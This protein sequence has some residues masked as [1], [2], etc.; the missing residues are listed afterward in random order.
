L[1]RQYQLVTS[2]ASWRFDCGDLIEVEIHDGLEGVTGCAI[3]SSVGKRVKPLGI[4]ALLGDQFGDSVAPALRSATAIDGSPVADNYR[5][6]MAGAVAGLALGAGEG[7]LARGP[8]SGL[9]VL[10]H[11]ASF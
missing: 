9:A 6:G 11:D 7:S 8:T 1:R 2:E 3:A 4:S 10:G 5:A